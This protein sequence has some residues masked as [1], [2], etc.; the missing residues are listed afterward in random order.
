MHELSHEDFYDLKDLASR[1]QKSFSKN[2][3]N[4]VFKISDVR[5]IKTE[6]GEPNKLFYKT[7][8]ANDEFQTIEIKLA[9]ES[10]KRTS[11]E[12]N[13]LILPLKKL[14]KNKVKI[15]EKKKQSIMSLFQ[16]KKRKCDC[17]SYDLFFI[18]QWVI[19]IKS[20]FCYLR[21][22]IISN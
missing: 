6:K 22:I 19:M 4:E 7:S 21:H 12:T 15:S 5:V 18:F 3:H 1:T 8:F 16:Q 9:R 10:N 2:V 20:I 17:Y 11:K 14:Y 13:R